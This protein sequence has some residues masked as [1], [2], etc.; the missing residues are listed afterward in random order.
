MAR[1]ISL[2]LLLATIALIG[3][4]FVA[5][6]GQFLLPLFLAVL[7]TILARPLHE[8]FVR[9]CRGRVRL[10]AAA[11]TL[12]IT[13]IVLLPLV[14]VLVQAAAQGAGVV[15]SIDQEKLRQAIERRGGSILETARE[16]AKEFNLE[17]PPDHELVQQATERFSSWIVPAALGT[18]Q[19]VGGALLSLAIMILA[20]Y[21]FLADGPDFVDGILRLVPIARRNQLQILAEFGRVSRAV[22]MA[23][24]LS[25]VSQGV[26]AGIGY[27]LVGLSPIVLLSV[28]TMLLSLVPFVGAAAV[29]GSGALWLYLVAERTGAAIGLVVWGVAFVTMIDNVIKPWVLRGQSNLHPLWAL[30]SVIGGVNA[31]GAIGILVGPMVVALLQSLLKILRSELDAL[32][33]KP[34]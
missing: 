33:A 1:W 4:L 24:L 19:F 2:A 7:L 18:T 12:S 14:W 11:T 21:F 8:W 27:W 10:A 13:L 34:A 6:M 9:K 25:S 23:T 26:V 17:I 31:L 15:R 30:L 22:V 20:V 32:E 29:W 16:R 3:W 5:V 28:M